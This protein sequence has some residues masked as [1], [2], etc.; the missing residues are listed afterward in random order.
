MD[1]FLSIT[2]TN[3]LAALIFFMGAWLAFEAMVDYSPLR[4]RGLSWLMAVRRRE[5]MLTLAERDLRMI[6][7][8]I[9]AGLQ[10]GAAFFGSTTILAVGGCFA[11]FGSTDAVLQIYR[12]VPFIEPIPR[13]VF[14]LKVFGLTTICVYGFFKFGWAYRLFNYCSILI[15]GVR[16]VQDA[17]FEERKAAA[18]RAAEMNIIAGRHFTAG[19]RA[20]FFA[21]AYIGW[22]VGPWVLIGSTVFVVLVLTRRQFFSNA[23]RI[24]LD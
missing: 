18:L 11:L 6:D 5:W 9:V 7:T 15:G 23:R 20:I 8:A 19:M 17:P 14:E 10:Q 22:F 24:L 2:G 4:F 16:H 13:G 3:D 21:L 1:A 12:D